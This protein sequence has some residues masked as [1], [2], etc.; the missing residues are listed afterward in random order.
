MIA[1]E[2]EFANRGGI[3]ESAA[4]VEQLGK[5]LVNEYKREVRATAARA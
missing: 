4:A 3:A 1:I 2:Q 5:Q